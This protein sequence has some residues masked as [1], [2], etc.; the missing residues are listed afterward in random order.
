MTADQLLQSQPMR[1]C[2]ACFTKILR[3]SA[4]LKP[5]MYTTCN[6][7][8]CFGRAMLTLQA[9]VDVNRIAQNSAKA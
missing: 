3:H 8:C 2:I 5:E 1:I 9:Y 4:H 6:N 7:P